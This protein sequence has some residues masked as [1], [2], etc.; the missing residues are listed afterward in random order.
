MSKFLRLLITVSLVFPVLLTLSCFTTDVAEDAVNDT[1]NEKVSS[2]LLTQI[3]MREE[4]IAYPTSDRLETMKDL[5]MRIDNL[6]VQRIFIHL[7]QELST[8]QI[9]ELEAIGITLYPD[10]WIPPVGAHSTG[11]LIADMPIDIL[12]ELAVKEFIVRLDT[13]ERQLEPQ[14][15]SQP[16][17]E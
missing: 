13:P 1:A 9:Q 16:N 11:F 10:S 6:G 7:N 2:Q 15:G 8:S 12:D 4:Q 17:Q 14:A 3:N 5:G